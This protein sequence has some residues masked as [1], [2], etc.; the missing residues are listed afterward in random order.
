MAV[1]RSLLL[2]RLLTLLSLV[3]STTSAKLKESGSLEGVWKSTHRDRKANATHDEHGSSLSAGDTYVSFVIFIIIFAALF[4]LFLSQIY[5]LYILPRQRFARSLKSVCNTPV[6]PCTSANHLPYAGLPSTW[7]VCHQQAKSNRV[8]YRK[9]SLTFDRNGTFHGTGEDRGESYVIHG[10]FNERRGTI[11]WLESRSGGR[12]MGV[13]E[14]MEWLSSSVSWF[15]V[16]SSSPTAFHGTMTANPGWIHI[17][18]G[19]IKGRDRGHVVMEPR[20]PAHATF[21]FPKAVSEALLTIIVEPGDWPSKSHCKVAVIPSGV[22]T[23]HVDRH[24]TESSPAA[25]H[26]DHQARDGKCRSAP[27]KDRKHSPPEPPT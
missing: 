25:A 21:K 17:S 27:G 11:V 16:S 4:V 12:G 3:V 8:Q 10:K 23:N 7:R 9:C 5:R 20:G 13:L 18:A 24:G 15:S 1:Q 6:V 22:G 26:N 2:A 19:Y 14:Y